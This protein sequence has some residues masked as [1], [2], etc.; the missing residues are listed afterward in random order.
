MPYFIEEIII[1]YDPDN[2]NG[3]WEFN[4]DSSNNEELLDSIDFTL[5]DIGKT[6]FLVREEVEQALKKEQSEKNKKL[7]GRN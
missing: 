6:V 2:K 3:Y 7:K 4:A 5:D 1:D